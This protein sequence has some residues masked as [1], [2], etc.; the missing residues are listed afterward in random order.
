LKRGAP[1]V[2]GRHRN[3]RESRAQ[4]RTRLTDLQLQTI[5]VRASIVLSLRGGMEIDG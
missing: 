4:G 2:L 5:D 1:G 3:T